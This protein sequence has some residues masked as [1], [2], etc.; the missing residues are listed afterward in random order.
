[1]FCKVHIW[2]TLYIPNPEVRR[3]YWYTRSMQTNGKFDVQTFGY[4]VLASSSDLSAQVRTAAL[5]KSA[6]VA[7]PI[8]SLL[9]IILNY[10][11]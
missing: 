6:G 2:N 7:S 10:I 5:L 8:P 11:E 9:S 3:V 4:F 1:M